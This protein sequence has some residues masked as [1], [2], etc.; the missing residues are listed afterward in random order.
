MALAV[1]RRFPPDRRHAVADLVRRLPPLSPACERLL[2]ITAS[3][4]VELRELAEVVASD[5]RMAMKVIAYAN[6]AAAERRFPVRSVREAVITIGV[7]ETARLAQGA[8]LLASFRDISPHLDGHAVI[9]A[10]AKIASAWGSAGEG[11]G[12]AGVIHFAGLLIMSSAQERFGRFRRLVGQARHYEALHAAEVSLYGVTRCDLAV[13]AAR[14]WRL[15]DEL[16]AVLDRWH[17]CRGGDP[18][19]AL[20]AHEVLTRSA[21]PLLRELAPR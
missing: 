1:T 7:M 12:A 15:P 6:S 13:I 11:A 20:Q 3:S 4:D 14:T 8:A 10:G 18:T 5:P 19:L 17:L 9:S 2:A 21:D 16:V